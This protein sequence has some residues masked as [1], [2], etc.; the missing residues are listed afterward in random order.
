[1][2]EIIFLLLEGQLLDFPTWKIC[3]AAPSHHCLTENIFFH[4]Y[5]WNVLHMKEM[6]PLSYF[7]A[8]KKSMVSLTLV[9]LKIMFPL[10]FAPGLSTSLSALSLFF[11]LKLQCNV[12]R[13]RFLFN[14][15]VWDLGVSG[16]CRFLSFR[17][18]YFNH[19][20]FRHILSHNPSFLP[21]GLITY[22]DFIS[23]SFIVINLMYSSPLAFLG[24]IL[25]NF[26][27]PI[28]P[29][30]RLQLSLCVVM[31]NHWDFNFYYVFLQKFYFFS[32]LLC[33]FYSF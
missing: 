30:L 16:I 18:R 15:P 14:Y 21:V 28:F 7:A 12:F 9:P 5:S 27:Q 17:I 10:W 33:H 2:S 1:M 26:F 23:V 25:G 11:F 31:A 3:H 32:E 6:I 20:L 24:W 22:P 4:Q 13:C 29:I 19:Y 8:F